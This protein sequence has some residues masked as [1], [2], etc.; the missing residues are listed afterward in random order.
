MAL[1]FTLILLSS[2]AWSASTDVCEVLNLS[3]CSGVQKMGRR[4]SAQSIPSTSTAAQFNPANVSHDRGFGVETMYQPGNAP[5]FSFVS[6]TGKV[7]A[8]LVSSKVENSFFGNR[9]IELEEDYFE[10]REDDEQYASEKQTLALGGGLFKNR[11]FSLDLGLLFKYNSDIKRVNPGAGFA[12][13]WAFVNFGAAQYQDD[14]KL[15]FRDL[16]NPN[17]GI[18]YETEWEDDEY[19]ERFTVRNYF[20]GIKIKN[21]FLDAGVINTTYKFDDDDATVIRLYSAAYIWKNF[22]FNLA[23]REEESPRWRYKDE[24]LLDERKKN[25]TYGGVQ[26]S[27]NQH[28]IIGVHYNYYLLREYAA[29]LTLFI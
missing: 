12:V 11:K 5:T 8:A 16:V 19:E 7:G 21:L 4:S 1:I 23:L 9:V 17:T 13:R 6:G 24:M 29:S 15:K 3:N 27:F 22:L 26:Y 10:R 2:S 14:V 28:F 18:P 25:E 20:A